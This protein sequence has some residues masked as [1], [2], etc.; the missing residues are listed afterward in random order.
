MTKFT[1]AYSQ[2]EPLAPPPFTAL[3]ESL[4][5]EGQLRLL[6]RLGEQALR[7]DPDCWSLE[8]VALLRWLGVRRFWRQP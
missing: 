1:L 8:F 3:C 7:E 6:R 4:P 2:F 5:R